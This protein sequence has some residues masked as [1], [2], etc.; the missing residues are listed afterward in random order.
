MATEEEDWLA[1]EGAPERAQR[2]SSLGNADCFLRADAEANLDGFWLAANNRWYTGQL[3][4]RVIAPNGL[5]LRRV[6]YAPAY[7]AAIYGHTAGASWEKRLFVAATGPRAYLWIRGR[8]LENSGTVE[9]A[10][11][12][13]VGAARSEM[14][15]AQ[16][17]WQ[18]CERQWKLDTEFADGLRFLPR[19]DGADGLMLWASQTPQQRALAEPAF[20]RLRFAVP[21]DAEGRLDFWLC[22]TAWADPA[23]EAEDTP[24]PA[25]AAFA[26]MQR[27]LA[28]VVGPEPEPPANRR[29][30]ERAVGWG[31]VCSRR[32]WHCY[33]AAEAGFTN[34]PPG[35]TI[36]TRDA[37]W[38]VFGA[39]HFAPQ[40][41]RALLE[42]LA[43]HAVYPSGKIAEYVRLAP[44][45][46]ER[47]DYRLNINDATPLFVLAIDH[48]WRQTGDRAAL[49]ALYPAA[50]GAA[51]WILAQRRDDGLVWCDGRGTNVFGIGGW[52][53]ILPGYR[54]AGA[55]TELNAECVAALR[56]A[57]RLAEAAGDAAHRPLFAQGA[58]QLD[59]AMAQLIDPQTGLFLL[60]RDERGPNLMLALDLALPALFAAGPEEARIR[61]LLRLTEPDFAHPHGLCTLS[62]NDPAYHPRFGW[63]LM[64]GSW[65]NATAWGAAALA[66]YRPQRAW[67][68]AEALARTLF[69]ET[70]NAP[71]GVGVPGQFP[72]WF[73]GDTGQS[74]GMS[75]SPWM[76]AT[77]VW[78]VREALEGAAPTLFP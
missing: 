72:E 55:L 78:L 60:N 75:L 53:N 56:A 42:T 73:D 37:A 13:R 7:Q 9:I 21:V 44:T 31:K 11:E 17:A 41:S 66:P 3:S 46:G 77:Y 16:P 26:G 27:A 48:H 58:S 50:R 14:H 1:W 52:R 23:Q 20:V 54:L 64:G 71:A 6:V 18:D 57:A 15:R 45:G 5:A 22:L 62:K 40:W 76:P 36:V 74:A 63:G 51:Q 69:P 35:N 19:D 2:G 61:T 12:W 67:E 25:A 28:E 24:P 68:L 30:V 38:F 4:L 70:W 39:D 33:A 8:G 32:V 65:P 47:D 10:C 59:A 34:D 29:L 43:R 49:E